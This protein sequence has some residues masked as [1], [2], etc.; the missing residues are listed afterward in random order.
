MKNKSRIIII[1]PAASGKDFLKKKFKERGFELDVSYTSRPPREGEIDGVDYHFLTELEFIDKINDFYESTKHGPYWYGT[2][3]YE[4]DNYDVFIMETHGISEIIPEDRKNC[5]IIYLNPP[6]YIREERLK[7]LRGWSVE[8]I[9][10]RTEMDN[11]KFSTF[12]DFD[13]EITNPDF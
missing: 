2:G 11:E 8:Q 10:H 7:E 3:Q 4:W 5:F 6:H 12:T 13:M 9:S 1:G